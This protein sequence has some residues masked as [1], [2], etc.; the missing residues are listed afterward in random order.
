MS[1]TNEVI[2]EWYHMM[3]GVNFNIITYNDEKYVWKFDYG[4]RGKDVAWIVGREEFDAQLANLS[5]NNN[6]KT[7]VGLKSFFSL[8][9]SVQ[10]EI[11]VLMNE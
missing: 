2:S 10:K 1:Y 3:D 8:P 6:Y 11:Q 5:R 4:W 9:E 7:A